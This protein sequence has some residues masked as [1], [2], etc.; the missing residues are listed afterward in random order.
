ME[1]LNNKSL[2][3]INGG[4]PIVVA[5]L[6]AAAGYVGKSAFDHLDYIGKGFKKGY[7]GK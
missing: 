7:Y 4:N 1:K 6:T 3:R 5:A 2:Q